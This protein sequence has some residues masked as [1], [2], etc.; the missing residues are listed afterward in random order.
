MSQ[1]IGTLLARTVLTLCV[2]VLSLTCGAQGQTVIEYET[3][4]YPSNTYNTSHGWLVSGRGSAYGSIAEAMAFTP[5]VTY[6]L[7]Y[8]DLAMSYYSGGPAKFRVELRKDC[9]G[10]PCSGT[11]LYRWSHMAAPFNLGTCCA[12]ET[13]PVDADYA[14]FAGR[15][16]WVVAKADVPTSTSV[17]AWNLNVLGATGNV[18]ISWDGGAWSPYSGEPLAAFRIWGH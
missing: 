6:K 9:G 3:L 15:Q 14:V 18:A 17:F 7:D 5:A 4:P 10:Q 12:I 1:C 16:Y 8:I 11:P 13:T 2:A